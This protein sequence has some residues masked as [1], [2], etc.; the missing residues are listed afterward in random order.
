M[1]MGGRKKECTSI[2]H[3]FKCSGKWGCPRGYIL[4]QDKC[5][6]VVLQLKPMMAAERVCNKEGATLVAPNTPL[7]VRNDGHL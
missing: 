2:E 1:D 3:L 4:M 7:H 5:Y 6:R